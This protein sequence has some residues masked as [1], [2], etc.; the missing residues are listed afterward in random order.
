[1]LCY[2]CYRKFGVL[3]DVNEDRFSVSELDGSFCFK[4]CK[5]NREWRVFDDWGVWF[6]CV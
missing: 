2:I 4:Y 6:D 5:I 3:G 1:M